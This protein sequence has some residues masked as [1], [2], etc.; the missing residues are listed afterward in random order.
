MTSH[1][2]WISGAHYSLQ[3]VR[4]FITPVVAGRVKVVAV[5]AW[6]PVGSLHMQHVGWVCK[7]KR[8]GVET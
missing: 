6:R 3:V 4:E 5:G 7:G 1:C 2:F 8:A